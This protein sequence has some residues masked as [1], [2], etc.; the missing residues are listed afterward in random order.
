MK[1]IQDESFQIMQD[2]SASESV[3]DLLIG[4]LYSLSESATPDDCPKVF[5]IINVLELQKEKLLKVAD[6]LEMLSCQ[7][8]KQAIINN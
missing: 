3:F 6:D 4:S 8:A 1:S 5:G 7:G 2:V